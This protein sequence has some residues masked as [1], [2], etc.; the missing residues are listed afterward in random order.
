M[1]DPKKTDDDE[2]DED[3]R[4]DG[5]E[6]P[7]EEAA[8]APSDAADEPPESESE[9][10]D[11]ADEREAAEETEAE[12]AAEEGS[13]EEDEEED[14]ED[15]EADEQEEAEDEERDEDDEDEERDED[16][17][18]EERDEDDEEAGRDRARK[19]AAALG[20][21]DDDE[22]DAAKAKPAPQNRAE[23]RRLLAQK[24][25]KGRAPEKDQDEPPKDRNL[26]KRQELLERRKRAAAAA[27]SPSEDE[28]SDVSLAVDD[29]LARGGAATANWIKRNWR[30]MQWALFASMIAGAG[31]FLYV[32]RTSQT[33]AV[34]SDKLASAV[35]AEQALVVP[36][37]KDKRSDDE[38]KRDFRLIY[39]SYEDRDKAAL[40]RYAAAAADGSSS[41]SAILAQLGL[42]GVKLD[43]QDWDA[44]IA[45]YD[46]V[47]R[48]K[49]AAADQDVKARALE[50]LGF[51]YEGKKDLDKANEQFSAL[52]ELAGASNKLLSKYHRARMLEAKGDKDGAK[53]L[54]QEAEKE[55]DKEKLDALHA[56]VKDGYQMVEPYR[57]LDD[58]IDDAIHRVD[59]SAP[60]R[61]APG[62]LPPGMSQE[63]LKA[64]LQSQTGGKPMLP[65][66]PE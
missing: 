10:L 13:G 42:A 1:V 17:E 36:P 6:A 48:S 59:P 34:A 25:R 52:G 16:D 15:E 33:S 9:Q 40:E 62:K 19:A 47:V 65:V 5:E 49:L 55:L 32:W 28:P 38:K 12:E 3:E 60:P 39:A 45:A 35:A 7:E 51:A 64:W 58:A 44:A 8:D 53:K 43:K 24:R 26:R 11:E 18:D 54:L 2:R 66:H 50:G 61:L 23:R 30:W 57:W 4:D 20:V 14:E 37:D 22:A 56:G 31:V 46:A 29:A 21:G 63:Q 41:G 27:A